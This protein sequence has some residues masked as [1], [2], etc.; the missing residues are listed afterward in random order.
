MPG[1]MDTVLN[2]GLNDAVVEALAAKTDARF[3]WDSYR[4]FI[5]LFASVVL[6]VEHD[7]FEK[8][9]SALKV[10]RPSGHAAVLSD[11]RCL[12]LGTAVHCGSCRQMKA[13]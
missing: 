9:M 7:E 2:L 6:G 3:A 13:G 12:S 4:R 8:H 1:M 5:D 10:L 11:T